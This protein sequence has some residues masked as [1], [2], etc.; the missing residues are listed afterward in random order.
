MAEDPNALAVQ[1][2]GQRA[3]LGH[4]VQELEERLRE[5]TDWRNYVR[6]RPFAMLASAFGL[7]LGIALFFGKHRN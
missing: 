1:I 5:T 6:R 7:G 3:K 2:Q 4:H